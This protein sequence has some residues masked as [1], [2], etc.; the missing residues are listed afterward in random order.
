MRGERPRRGAACSRRSPP[1]TS[2]SPARAGRGD[3]APLP[4]PTRRARQR[5]RRGGALGRDR[6]TSARS[7]T[8]CSSAGRRRPRA[9]RLMRR[10]G[11]ALGHH[12][13]AARPAGARSARSALASAESGR[14]SSTST[15]SSPRSSPRA[16]AWRSTTRACTPSAPRSP[17]RCRSSS[18]PSACPT[19]RGARVAARYRAAGELNEVGGDFYD[20]FQRSPDRVGAR[21]RRRVGQGRRGGRRHGAGALHA[22]CRGARGRPAAAP[23]CSGSTSDARHDDTRSSPPSCWPTSPP[24]RTASIDLRLALA[25]HPA[26]ACCAATGASRWSVG[27]GRIARRCARH[28]RARRRRPPRAR[29]RAAALHRRR[30][31]SGAAARRRSVRRASPRCCRAWPGVRREEVVDAVEQAV[32]AAQPGDPRDD[33]AL[34]AIC[35]T[36]VDGR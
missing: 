9:P 24:G 32:V 7:P 14:L 27:S 25:G 6:A 34:L 13:P 22:A 19:S 15:S 29:R 3:H 10:L 18:C 4:D 30:D 11:P 33:I 8:R 17:T 35:P 1:R 16:P 36:G 20:V 23:P 21:R 28:R 26:P 5:R 2:T 12:R 31:R